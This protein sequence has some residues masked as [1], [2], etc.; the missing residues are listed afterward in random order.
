[1]KGW[2]T[3]EQFSMD[4]WTDWLDYE[5]GLNLGFL[6]GSPSGL[7]C[8]DIDN[9]EGKGIL[10]ESGVEG[11]DRTWQYT[12]GR[13]LRSLFR[14]REVS[15]S[16]VVTRGSAS[17]EVLGD[18]RQSVLPPSLHPNGRRYR[19]VDGFTPRTIRPLRGDGWASKLAPTLEI[20]SDKEDW[21]RNVQSVTQEG[22]RNTT[23]VRLAGH[24]LNPCPMPAEEAY[25]WLSLYNQAHCKPPLSDRELR[26]IISCISKKEA[27][28][29]AEKDREVRELMKRYDMTY[30]QA[31]TMWRGM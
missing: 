18:G 15:T 19:W 31:E 9:E 8:I 23:L 4:Q 2:Q 20:T 3:H 26:S 11:W 7:I 24:L 22:N 30:D 14:F 21:T 12:T 16:C 13:G 29:Q 1:M 28:Q 6:C 10:H 17:Y 25:I 27:G 5:S